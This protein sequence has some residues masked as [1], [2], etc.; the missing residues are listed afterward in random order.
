MVTPTVEGVKRRF[1][2]AIEE[3]RTNGFFSDHVDRW[4][5]TKK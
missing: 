2:A 4:L 1:Y 5:K 3:D